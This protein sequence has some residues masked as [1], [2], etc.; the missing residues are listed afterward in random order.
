[1]ASNDRK[2][3]ASGPPVV[4]R[5]RRAAFDY[6]IEETVE[7]GIVLSGTEVKS[8]RQGRI[9]L[10]QA[11]ARIQDG[12]VWLLGM[13]IPEYNAASWTNHAPQAKR[14]LLLH[15]RQ[16]AKIEILVV[17]TGRTLIPLDIHFNERGIA[18]VLLAVA[19]GKKH[20]DKRSDERK[21]EADLEIRSF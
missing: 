5:N 13:N 17:R 8:L 18:K 19:T 20:H 6:T 9:S 3:K 11:Y 4:A 12:E 16:I 21:K 10:D 14:K 2:K 15:K 7:A 1:M